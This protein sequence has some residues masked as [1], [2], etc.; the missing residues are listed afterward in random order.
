MQEIQNVGNC[1]HNPIF[2]KPYI[3]VH[4]CMYVSIYVCTCVYMFAYDGMSM[5]TKMEGYVNLRVGG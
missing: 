3:P 4:I 1:L 5:D 2:A